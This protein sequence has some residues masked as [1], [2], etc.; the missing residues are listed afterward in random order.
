M[1]DGIAAAEEAMKLAPLAKEGNRRIVLVSAVGASSPDA[2]AA[3]PLSVWNSASARKQKDKTGYLEFMRNAEDMVMN[4]GGGEFVIIR[5]GD[6]KGNAPG[7]RQIETAGLLLDNAF[8]VY[9]QDLNVYIEDSAFGL[10]RRATLAA[11]VAWAALAPSSQVA[12]TAFTALSCEQA[13]SVPP[14]LAEY[15]PGGPPLKWLGEKAAKHR[16]VGYNVAH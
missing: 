7:H 4:Q 1:G 3:P 13:L 10:T 14:A 15:W 6:L 12:N 5:A 8:D 2:R 9:H 11:A 16:R